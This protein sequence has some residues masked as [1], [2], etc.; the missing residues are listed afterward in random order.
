MYRLKITHRGQAY[1]VAVMLVT[2]IVLSLSIIL[3]GYMSGWVSEKTEAVNNV[4]SALSIEQVNGFMDR[5]RG[6]LN[7]TIYARNSGARVVRVTTVFLLSPNNTV[8]KID[9]NTSTATLV[10]QGIQPGK[11]GV[12]KVSVKVEANSG[13]S[14]IWMVKIIGDDGSIAIS[15][16]EIV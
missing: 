7:I 5:S 4:N 15:N 14:G 11:V 3:Y 13:N 8:F 12:I 1:V 10:S 16:V 9:G 2:L 6:A